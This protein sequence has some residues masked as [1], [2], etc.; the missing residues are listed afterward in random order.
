M[1]RKDPPFRRATP[2]P[3]QMTEPSSHA[4]LADAHLARLFRGRGGEATRGA[5]ASS[6]TR[7]LVN[8]A[9][10]HRTILKTN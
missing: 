5:G 7:A 8:L 9:E 1:V 2:L 10:G 6:R 4:L 3:A